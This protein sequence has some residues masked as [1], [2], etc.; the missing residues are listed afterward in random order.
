ILNF[1]GVGRTAFTRAIGDFLG[2]RKVKTVFEAGKSDYVIIREMLA[3][4]GYDEKK[5]CPEIYERIKKSFIYF[6][7]KDAS[8]NTSAALLP[9]ANETL[10]RLSRERNVFQALLT[11]NFR[12]TAMEKL[13]RFNIERYFLTGGFGDDAIERTDIA[14]VSLEKAKKKFNLVDFKAFVVG[15]TASDVKCGKL[16]GAVTV[17]IGHE[18]SGADY[19]IQNLGE[20]IDIIL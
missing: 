7:K 12:E 3:A 11:G 4:N 5:I 15:D 17:T 8:E 13:K 20:L 19:C 16:L 10:E 14:R 9:F 2:M 6:F 18:D 1:G